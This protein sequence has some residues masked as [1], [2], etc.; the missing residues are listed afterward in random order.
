MVLVAASLGVLDAAI[1]ANWD[2]VVVLGVIAVVTVTDVVRATSGRAPIRLRADLV[3]WMDRRAAAH[4]ERVEDVAD[5]AVAA[6]RAGL[7]GN[8]D[9]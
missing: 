4:G 5:R 3:A 6:Y 9:A 1:G 8:E 2:L 7:V